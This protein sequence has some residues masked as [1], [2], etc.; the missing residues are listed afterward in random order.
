MPN[1]TSLLIRELLGGLLML[2]KSC[3]ELAIQRYLSLEEEMTR[4]W[5]MQTMQT[6]KST[7]ASRACPWRPM[8]RLQTVQCQKTATATRMKRW[9]PLKPLQTIVM[10]QSQEEQEE[11]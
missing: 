3:R 5:T 6:R 10:M 8:T 7:Q 9:P 4:T 11:L 1:R 2:L